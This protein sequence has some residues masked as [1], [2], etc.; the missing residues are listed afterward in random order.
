MLDETPTNRFTSYPTRHEGKFDPT[1][2]ARELRDLFLLDPS[3]V[4]LNHGSFGAC[5]EP[6]FDTYQRWQRELERQPVL[7]LGRRADALLDEARAHLAAYLGTHAENLVFV[8]N[9][10]VGG[11][12]VARALKLKPGDEILTTDHEYGAMDKTWEFIC[13]RTGA[14]YVRHRVPLPVTTHEAFVESFWSAVTPRTR[15]IF[16]SHITSPTALRFPIEAICRRAREAGIL[17]IIDGAHAPGQIP[18]DLEAIGADFYTGNCHKWLCAPKGAAFLYARPEHHAASEP[19]VVSWG[20]SSEATFVQKHQWQGTRDI[21]AYLSIPAAIDF[22]VAHD[23][24]AVRERCH[25]LARQ[26][27]RRMTEITGLEAISPDS[28]DWFMQLATM[29]IPACDGAALQRR[30]WEEHRIEIPFVNWN[31]GHYLRLSVQ[32]YTTAEEVEALMSAVA[33]CAA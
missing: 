14:V 18:L 33:V 32:G 21:A 31:G 19:L 8:A 3:V 12:T 2:N 5:P 7:F 26:A 22:Q 1:M 13:G 4:F 20:W 27:R 24:D 25:E 17:T 9:A 28:R 15:V 23:W 6:V 29:P 16:M 30:L 11:N 10:T